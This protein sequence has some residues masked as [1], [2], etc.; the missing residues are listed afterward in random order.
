MAHV[1]SDWGGV[2][3]DG[4]FIIQSTLV[5]CWEPLGVITVIQHAIYK[6][7]HKITPFSL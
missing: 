5:K 6:Y 7:T 1:R 3:V 4:G 2:P